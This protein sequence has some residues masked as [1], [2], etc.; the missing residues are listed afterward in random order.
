MTA[1]FIV[2]EGLEGSGKSTAMQVCQSVLSSYNKPFITTREPGGTHV[3][4]QLRDIV[5][6]TKGEKISTQTELLLMYGARSQLVEQ[7]IRPAL[8][9]G[10]WVLGDRHDLSS[11]AYQ[12]GGRGVADKTLAFL[13]EFVLDGLTPDLTLYLDIDPKVGLQRARGRGELDRIEQE[14]IAFFERTRARYLE[15]AQADESIVIIDAQ[16]NMEK[17][18]QDITV[19]VSQFIE[20]Q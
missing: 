7:V 18:H 11:K 6:H 20:R 17:V 5:K 15:L 12:G 2:I 8:Q 16:Q 4:E 1:K 10:T 14:N 3:A 13:S 19:A 9:D